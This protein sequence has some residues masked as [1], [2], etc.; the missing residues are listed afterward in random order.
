M[1]L[2]TTRAILRNYDLSNLNSL[3]LEPQNSEPTL[4]TGCNAYK[5]IRF[6]DMSLLLQIKTCHIFIVF[7]FVCRKGKKKEGRK[8][9]RRKE[10]EE[11]VTAKRTSSPSELQQR[12]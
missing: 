7:V 10:R 2:N 5:L 11:E 12:C 4:W 9:K 1:Y 8:R 6:V 3:R